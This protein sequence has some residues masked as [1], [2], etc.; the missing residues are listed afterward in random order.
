MKM[1]GSAHNPVAT[2][3]FELNGEKKIM[4]VHSVDVSHAP[5]VAQDLHRLFEASCLDRAANLGESGLCAALEILSLANILFGLRRGLSGRRRECYPQDQGNKTCASFHTRVILSQENEQTRVHGT[6]A[7][8]P[9]EMYVVGGVILRDFR[10][11]GS[12]V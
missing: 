12:G 2:V 1:E 5:A 11:E 7:T 9:L 6:A 3:K 8:A 4:L 10:P